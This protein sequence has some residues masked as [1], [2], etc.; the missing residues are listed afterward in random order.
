MDPMLFD[1][2]WRNKQVNEQNPQKQLEGDGN[3]VWTVCWVRGTSTLLCPFHLFISDFFF[4]STLHSLH[5]KGST[6]LF[7]PAGSLLVHDWEVT[8][9]Q[10]KKR[11]VNCKQTITEEAVRIFNCPM[12][13]G[14]KGKLS[15][16]LPDSIQVKRL[17]T[18]LGLLK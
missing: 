12:Q 17:H 15:T 18:K 6:Q 2:K 4:F 3:K 16:K 1:Q 11:P 8:Y 10:S 5:V 14:G 9:L 13:R 7:A